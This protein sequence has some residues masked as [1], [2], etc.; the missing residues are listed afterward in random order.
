MNKKYLIITVICLIISLISG[1]LSHDILIGGTNL[2]TALLCAYFSSEG[3]RISYIL[4]LI[5]YLLIGYTARLEKL[6]I[7]YDG[8]ILPCPAFKNYMLKL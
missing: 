2:L 3:K 8:T 7:K 5:N 6:N 4:G 1:I